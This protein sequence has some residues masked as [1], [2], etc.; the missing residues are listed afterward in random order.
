MKALENGML[1]GS[2]VYPDSLIPVASDRLLTA[3]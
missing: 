3:Y 2:I 1:A